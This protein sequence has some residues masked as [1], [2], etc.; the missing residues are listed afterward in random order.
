LAE[1]LLLPLQPEHV[2]V[3]E[4]SLVAVGEV[5]AVNELSLLFV[6]AEVTVIVTVAVTGVKAGAAFGSTEIDAPFQVLQSVLQVAG[7]MMVTTL[8]ETVAE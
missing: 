3:V 1:E 8:F 2:T 4:I 5:C 7:A 6:V